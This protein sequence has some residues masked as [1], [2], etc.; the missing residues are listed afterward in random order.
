MKN[1]PAIRER[2]LQENTQMKLGHLASDLA[3]IASL[4]NMQAGEKALQNVMEETKFF[5]EW[6][7][8]DTDPETQAFLLEIRSLITEKELEWDSLSNDENW[9]DETAKCLRNLSN[10]LLKKAGF[11]IDDRQ[12]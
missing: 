6:T 2:F 8:P 7:A 9:R 5:A 12:I 10:K 4:L 11:E 1:L 3:R